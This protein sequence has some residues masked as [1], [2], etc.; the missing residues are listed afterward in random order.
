MTP[1]RIFIIN[2]GGRINI[3]EAVVF[4]LHDDAETVQG[5]A[6][7]VVPVNHGDRVDRTDRIPGVSADALRRKA[8]RRPV[9]HDH[10]QLRPRVFQTGFPVR[11]A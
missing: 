2:Q 5:G 11:R 1:K 3:P 4:L 6:F 7:T 9:R 8:Q 10:E